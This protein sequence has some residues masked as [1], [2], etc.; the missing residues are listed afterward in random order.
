M[1]LARSKASL[2]DTTATKF[3]EIRVPSGEDVVHVYTWQNDDGERKY[4]AVALSTA[5]IHTKKLLGQV[6]LGSYPLF[7]LQRLVTGQ[8]RVLYVGV[9]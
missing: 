3:K 6:D 4:E 1:H 8:P 2:I 7:N 9:G 5:N